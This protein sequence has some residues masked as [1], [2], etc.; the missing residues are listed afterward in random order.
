MNRNKT[1][2]N[3]TD[4]IE[5][6]RVFLE[7]LTGGPVTTAEAQNVTN[8]IDYMYRLLSK[9]EQGEEIDVDSGK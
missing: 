6:E 9:K 4:K 2:D 7:K 8:Y 3:S 1:T 5:N